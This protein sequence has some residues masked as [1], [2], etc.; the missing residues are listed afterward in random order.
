MPSCWRT[1]GY[2]NVLLPLDQRQGLQ[3]HRHLARLQERRAVRQ[4]LLHADPPDLHSG[5]RRAPVQAHPHDRVA[6]QRRPHLGAKRKKGDKRRPTQIPEADRDYYLE[7][8]YPELRQP[9]AARRRFTRGQGG[10]RRRPRRRPSGP[11]R[12]SRFRDAIKRL[13]EN[14][15]RERYGN[16]FDMYE[17]HHRARTATKCR[18]GSIP[19]FTTPWAACGWTTT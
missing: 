17:T 7:R 9:G 15:I 19:P 8:K 4:P 18:C 6:A 11:G 16:L 12:L 5:H 14:V 3:R 10:L 2:G 13:G 1:G